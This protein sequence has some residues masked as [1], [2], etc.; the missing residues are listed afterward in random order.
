MADFPENI[1]FS[2]LNSMEQGFM[3]LKGQYQPAC[4]LRAGN[5]FSG[6]PIDLQQIPLKGS[7][8]TTLFIQFRK[9][10][11]YLGISSTGCQQDQQGKVDDCNKRISLKRSEEHTS[12]LQS[13]MRISYAFFC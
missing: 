12:E 13:L 9:I 10:R 3:G 7:I 2:Q 1:V 5:I 8:D 6:I 4:Q 11:L